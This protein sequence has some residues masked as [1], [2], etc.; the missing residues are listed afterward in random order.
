MTLRKDTEDIE[1]YNKYVKEYKIFEKIFF[2]LIDPEYLI[3][4][5]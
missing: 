5:H 4:L 1:D 3:L 2:I